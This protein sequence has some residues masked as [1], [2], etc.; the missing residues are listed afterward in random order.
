MQR[1]LNGFVLLLFLGGVPT[2]ANDTYYLIQEMEKLR[3]SLERDDPSRFDLTLRLADL[4]FDSSI[5]EGNKTDLS[6]LKESRLKALK[7]YEEGLN[8]KGSKEFS[9]ERQIKIEFQMARLLTR[10]EEFKRA[11]KHYLNVFKKAQKQQTKIKEQASL[12]LAEW[13]E[14]EAFFKKA[15]TFYDEAINLCDSQST[16]NYIHYRKGWLYF[17]ETKLTL[18]IREMKASLWEES[19]EVRESSLQDLILFMS[20]QD[21]DGEKEF[22]TLKSLSEKLKRP[23]LLQKL[24]EAFYVAGNRRAGGH[25]LSALNAKNPKLYFEVRLLEEFYG[26]RNWEKVDDLLSSLEKR[27]FQDIPSKEVTALEIRKIFRRYLVQIDSEA[28]GAPQLNPFLLRSIDIYLSLY[29][30]D[31][32]RVKL[33]QGWLKAQE[34]DILK[35]DRLGEW[36][37]EDLSFGASKKHIRNLRQTRLSLAKKIQLDKNEN[38]QNSSI[39]LKESLALSEMLKNTNQADEFIYITA[40]EYYKRKDYKSAIPLFKDL[41]KRGLENNRLEK[42]PLL[43]Q[44]LLLDIYNAQDKYQ[45]IIAQVKTWVDKTKDNNEVKILSETKQMKKLSLDARFAYAV[46]LGE[47]PKSL[48]EFFSFCLEKIHEKKSCDNARVLAVKLKDQSKLVTLL[49]KFGDEEALMTEYEIMGRFSDA[50]LL[51]EKRLLRP[52]G[53]KASHTLFLKVALLYELDEEFGNRDR[54]LKRLIRKIK[55]EK[56]IPKKLEEAIFI[57][58]DDAG[59]VN[60]KLLTLPWSL[61]KK[62]SLANRLEL[63]KPDKRN[64]EIILGYP[65]SGPLWSRLILKQFIKPFKK[66]LG[67]KFYGRNSAYLFKKRTKSIDR[68]VKF[69]KKY[70][71]KSASETRV[72][73]LHMLTRTYN[74]MV[75]DILSSPIPEGLDPNTYAQVQ[76]Q[77]QSLS[78]PFDKVRS[79]YQKLLD[80]EIEETADK[81]QIQENLSRNAIAYTDFIP[82]PEGNE[83]PLLK[84]KDFLG[85]RNLKK[86]LLK[87]PFKQD[88]LVSLK[89]HF[90]SKSFPRLASYFQGRIENLKE[91]DKI[92]SPIIRGLP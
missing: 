17:K 54:I 83:Y 45:E 4:Y 72:Y 56:N 48:D 33:Q 26:F 38:R 9:K 47:S 10:L 1:L 82:L 28:G 36:I 50:A 57:T 42:W 24:V 55:I 88:T 87:N 23:E 34:S 86:D 20:N 63:K 3:D 16:C 81:I 40:H 90:Q 7:L 44:N 5:K 74:K 77:L 67:P 79:D 19:G 21:T 6:I 18:A 22:Q 29:P 78:A 73:I 70:L 32:L 59:L 27:S 69:S 89:K 13:Y 92:T 80:N 85:S 12:A 68:F 30:N 75:E 60:S 2:L 66:S 64:R 52:K 71:E 91:A 65:E 76:T 35:R 46:T 37:I 51:Q 25:L 84:V 58:L 61:K 39:I 14:N 31:E 11:E 62:L 43:S 8:K 49:E 15:L 53:I 41:I